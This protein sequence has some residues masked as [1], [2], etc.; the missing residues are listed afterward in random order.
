MECMFLA[1]IP[2]SG[3]YVLEIKDSIYRGREDFVYRI[4][5]GEEPFVTGIF[6]LS[7]ARPIDA[8]ASALKKHT[9]RSSHVL[10]AGITLPKMDCLIYSLITGMFLVMLPLWSTT[11]IMSTEDADR[12]D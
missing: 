11:T 6:P 2:E 5:L 4:T 3:E 1:P 12:G 10:P 7:N 8:A 9:P